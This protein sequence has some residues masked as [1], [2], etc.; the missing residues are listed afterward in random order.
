[1][2]ETFGN[3]TGRLIVIAACLA[4]AGIA[5]IVKAQEAALVAR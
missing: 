3:L 1:M 2:Q 5:E 4:T